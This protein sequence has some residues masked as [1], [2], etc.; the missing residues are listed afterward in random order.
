M[1][2]WTDRVSLVDEKIS[3]P[4]VELKRL[5]PAHTHRPRPFTMCI[6]PLVLFIF[7]HSL[8]N[9]WPV[10]LVMKTQGCLV[11]RAETEK[12]IWWLD[13]A[14]DEEMT[15]V[16]LNFKTTLTVKREASSCN[17]QHGVFLLVLKCFFSKTCT[18]GWLEVQVTNESVVSFTL[19]TPGTL[20][21][22]FNHALTTNYPSYEGL[23]W[24]PG[25]L[26]IASLLERLSAAA[27]GTTWLK[28]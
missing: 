9:V 23:I 22:I 17:S 16:S 6:I 4:A 7:I 5:L 12:K 18:L 28:L 3:V 19:M 25:G 8:I 11:P 1:D 21:H 10:C 13:K 14:I 27:N 20:L 2:E 24:L 26:I 15:V